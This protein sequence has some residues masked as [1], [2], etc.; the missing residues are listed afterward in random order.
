VNAHNPHQPTGEP[1]AADDGV[2][3]QKTLV[4]QITVITKR[5]VPSL[6]SKRISLDADGKLKSDGSEC[7]MVTGTAER[8]SAETASELALIIKS[9]GSNQAIALGALKEDTTS[10]VDV[11]TKK[12]LGGNPGAIA[13]TS[14]FIDYQSTARL[15]HWSILTPRACPT[16]SRPRST[17][18][19]A[20]GTR[21]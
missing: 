6:M 15:G 4:P 10:P 5:D 12:R 21:S 19:G 18:Q 17:P 2:G 7:L 9:C 13:R 11:T 1:A 8:A 14:D 20:C 16:R 3:S